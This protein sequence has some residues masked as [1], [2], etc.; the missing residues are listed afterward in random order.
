VATR[1]ESLK[2]PTLVVIG[3]CVALSP[4]WP[5]GFTSGEEQPWVLQQGSVGSGV[6]LDAI[7]S[8]LPTVAAAKQVSSA[9]LLR[10][11]GGAR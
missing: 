10:N 6:Y 3:N 4:L 11:S 8:G 9:L 1:A 7:S 5:A 2:S